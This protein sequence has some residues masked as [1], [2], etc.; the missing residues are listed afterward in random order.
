MPDDATGPH[1]EPDH[2]GLSL[3]TSP[4]WLHGRPSDFTKPNPLS[5]NCQQ[6]EFMLTHERL[7]FSAKFN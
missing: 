7:D 4:S 1:E 3:S 2:I 5:I 6:L